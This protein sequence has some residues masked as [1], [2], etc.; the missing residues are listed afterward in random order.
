MSK[1]VLAIAAHP[2]DIEI[3]MAGTLF[4]LKEKGYDIHYMNV[5][6]GSCGT[7]EHDKESIIK[8][9][10][11]EARDACAYIGATYY[12][13]IC[14][15]LEIFYSNENL[16]KVAAVVRQAKPDIVLTHA[17]QDYME[18]HMITS[19]LAVTAAFSRGMPNY[20]TE[21][22]CEPI[23]GDVAV[24]QAM[25]HGLCDPLRQPVSSEFY[26]NVE[27][28]IDQKKEMLGKHASQKN[29]LDVSQGMDSYIVTMTE[30][31][32]AIGTCS[33]SYQFAEGWRRHLHWG[34]SA[35]DTDPL[36]EIL[37][38]DIVFDPGKTS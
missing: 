1:S 12:P 6:N 7:V 11:Q 20:I 33:G 13:S 35:D 25:P 38:D 8:I 21:P 24:Y 14:S 34:F 28:V 27:S 3:F 32:Q 26:V 23:Q 22:D 4:L 15:D 36:A 10:E 2:D 16:Q 9:R 17:P 30:F 19:R 37:S 29:W 31:M 5:A 18:D